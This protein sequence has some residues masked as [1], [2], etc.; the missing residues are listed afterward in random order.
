MYDFENARAS[1]IE[2]VYTVLRW[3][4]RRISNTKGQPLQLQHKRD[5][6]VIGW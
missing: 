1:F 3:E 2:K 4:A 5:T 6:F